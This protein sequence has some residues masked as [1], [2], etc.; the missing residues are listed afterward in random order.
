[1]M[2]FFS[3]SINI[4]SFNTK[5]DPMYPHLAL[6]IN[7][8]QHKQHQN[9]IMLHLFHEKFDIFRKYFPKIY[10]LGKSTIFIVLLKYENEL[11]II[12]RHLKR[13]V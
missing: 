10:F 3:L 5:Y 4:S 6:A 11:K 1:M 8:H 13:K 12:F 2:E 7:Q 9:H